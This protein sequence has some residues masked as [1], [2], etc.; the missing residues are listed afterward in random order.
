MEF[1]N[2]INENEW[3]KD[4]DGTIYTKKEYDAHVREMVRKQIGLEKSKPKLNN[5]KD[6]LEYICRKI[7]NEDPELLISMIIECNETMEEMQKEI[8]KLKSKE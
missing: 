4:E 2:Y 3:F 8:E 7:M 5:Q 6:L 1:K